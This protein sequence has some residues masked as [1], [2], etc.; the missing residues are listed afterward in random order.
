MNATA[1]TSSHTALAFKGVG[2]MFM[3]QGLLGK[4]GGFTAGVP[5]LKYRNSIERVFIV[6]GS[7]ASSH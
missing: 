6:P 1:N 7:Q 5:A 4:K 3:Q 2:K